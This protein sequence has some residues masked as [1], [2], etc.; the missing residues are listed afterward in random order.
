MCYVAIP[1]IVMAVA[2]IGTA[3]Y[4]ANQ[5]KI[6]TERQ[7]KSQQEQTDQ[8]AQAQTDDR[9]KAARE[10]RAAARA[11]S[12]ESGASG[13][14]TDAIMNDIMM[15]SGRDVSRIEKNRENG[16]LETSQQARSRY[17]EINGQLISSVGSS[18]ASAYSGYSA[19]TATPT[20]PTNAQPTKT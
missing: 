17:S 9:L 16:Q 15:Q 2:A 14:S 11:A 5:Q 8:G 7:M 10:Q 20:I 4:A 6:A 1:Y 3:A 12:A 13:N 18:A 19:K